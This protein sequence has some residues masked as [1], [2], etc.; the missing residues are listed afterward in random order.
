MNCIFTLSPYVEILFSSTDFIFSDDTVIIDD[1]SE[2]TSDHLFNENFDDLTESQD[3]SAQGE[4]TSKDD[5]AVVTLPKDGLR[6]KTQKRGRTYICPF[7]ES[8]H[9]TTHI[10]FESRLAEHVKRKHSNLIIGDTTV[11]DLVNDI[12]RHTIS[13]C[14]LNDYIIC[15]LCKCPERKK[16]LTKHLK[17][18]HDSSKRAVGL[19]PQNKKCQAISLRNI[20]EIIIKERGDSEENQSQFKDLKVS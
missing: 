18:L 14:N 12:K 16:H 4:G 5:F 2:T 13:E 7:R 3:Q 19:R 9:E 17:R 20:K 10:I 8:A 6:S 11:K 1:D 15:P